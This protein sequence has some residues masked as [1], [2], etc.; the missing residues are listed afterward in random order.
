[1]RHD[2]ELADGESLAAVRAD[3]VCGDEGTLA[4]RQDRKID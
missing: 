2:E 1:V 3:R 4:A